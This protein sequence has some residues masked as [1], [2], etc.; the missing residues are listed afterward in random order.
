MQFKKLAAIAGSAIMTGLTIAV[1]GLAAT[2]TD[3]SKINQLVT[4]NTDGSTTFPVF[5]TGATAKV[6]DVNSAIN[7][8][9]RLAAES[10]VGGGGT[11]TTTGVDGM[12]AHLQLDHPGGIQFS[13][14]NQA[15]GLTTSSSAQYAALV[16][17][18][19]TGGTTVNFLKT[20]KYTISDTEYTWK[21]VVNLTKANDTDAAWD[22]AATQS[23]DNYKVAVINLQSPTVQG[24]FSGLF[25]WVQFDKNITTQNLKGK[26]IRWLGKD[27]IVTNVKLDVSP[28][29][30]DI[31]D[32]AALKL[33]APGDVITVGTHKVTITSISE[34]SVGVTVTDSAGVS[35]SKTISEGSTDTVNGVQIFV[36][37]SVEAYVTGNIKTGSAELLMTE[38]GGIRALKDGQKYDGDW[39]VTINGTDSG[40]TPAGLWRVGI[41]YNRGRTSNLAIKE[42]ESVA[43]PNNFFVLKD[44]GWE[45]ST[46]TTGSVKVNFESGYYIDTNQDGTTDQYAIK[47]STPDLEKIFN[48]AG[49]ISG[50]IQANE[51]YLLPNVVYQAAAR[52]GNPWYFFIN[53]SGGYENTTATPTTV[54]T[55][56][57]WPN[58][59]TTFDFVN[60][61][62]EA[63]KISSGSI[64]EGSGV[65][66]F[67]SPDAQ[68][69]LTGNFSIEYQNQSGT[70][71]RRFNSTI[72]PGLTAAGSGPIDDDDSLSYV[73]WQSNDG[74]TG[75][76]SQGIVGRI[77][78]W[79]ARTGTNSYARSGFHSV[80]GARLISASETLVSIEVPKARQGIRLI[81]GQPSG[82]VTTSTG[83]GAVIPITA[84]V[85]GIDTDYASE[86]DVTTDV[87]VVG[88]PCINKLAAWLLD[89]T[90][91]ACGADSGVPT[92][93]AL[94]KLVADAFVT[95]KTALLVA[96]WEKGDTDFASRVLQNFATVSGLAGKS[97]ATLSGTVATSPTIE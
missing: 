45:T 57:S 18:G 70:F 26:T 40:V 55:E 39:Y 16:P 20:G 96:G 41:Y 4:V 83:G 28:K 6:E 79:L 25:Y 52:A 68:N 12:V 86:A 60:A 2:V 48:L 37:N 71:S 75:P 69:G 9:V 43:A 38:S 61:T 53:S 5:V 58:A 92:D 32:S 63:S 42:G 29:Q 27:Q 17:S 24:A 89:K 33:V 11:T 64:K 80:Y 72:G 8:A 3:L 21:E 87:I 15:R 95:G 97:S 91:P 56:N 23:Q 62:I 44:D 1:P 67:V 85:V 7:L 51:F 30:V 47:I 49:S 66:W 65:I 34:T 77:G 84:D 22:N 76:A 73:G 90:F 59:G 78:T 10:R 82:T 19:G 35:E 81:L 74:A 13:I 54:F 88:G 14:E 36:K 93:K 31:A 50:S 46:S 94:V